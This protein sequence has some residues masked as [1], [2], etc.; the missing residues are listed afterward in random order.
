MDPR[1]EPLFEHLPSS[2]PGFE[3]RST[4]FIREWSMDFGFEPGTLLVKGDCSDRGSIPGTIVYFSALW[5]SRSS[6]GAPTVTVLALKAMD[7]GFK[8]VSYHLPSKGRIPFANLSLSTRTESYGFTQGLE[9]N[10]PLAQ[11]FLVSSPGI[12]ARLASDGCSGSSAG[13]STSPV[14]INPAFS[15]SV[16]LN[17]PPN[18]DPLRR[19]LTG[20][21]LGLGLKPKDP[22]FK[23][24]AIRPGFETGIRRL[25]G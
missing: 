18:R 8:P 10:S 21:V 7:P 3:S 4:R 25:C 15:G 13:L 9:P 17:G 5:V 11:H 12:R 24:G 20:K 14:T 22:S 23:K 2:D 6:L 19:S 1:I 16:R